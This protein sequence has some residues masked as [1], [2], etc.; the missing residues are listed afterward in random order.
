M[1]AFV[2]HIKNK[3]KRPKIVTGEYQTFNN[4]SSEIWWD[5]AHKFSEFNERV[6]KSVT[7]ATVK[8]ARK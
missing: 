2:T 1:I 6:I 7:S 3:Q 5:I 8:I 4:M